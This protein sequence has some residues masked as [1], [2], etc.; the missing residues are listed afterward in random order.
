MSHTETLDFYR[1]QARYPE[2]A[3]QKMRGVES[4]P[5]VLGGREHPSDIYSVIANHEV[6][7]I[8]GT[9]ARFNINGTIEAAA[10]LMGVPRNGSELARRLDIRQVAQDAKLNPIAINVSKEYDITD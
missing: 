2:T 4:T 3:V 6:V 5:V 9:A 10:L 1:I 8:V 7:A